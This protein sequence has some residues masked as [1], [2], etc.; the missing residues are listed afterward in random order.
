[1]RQCTSLVLAG[2]VLLSVALFTLAPYA[3]CRYELRAAE[4]ALHRNDLELAR[5][6]LERSLAKGPGNTHALFLA[7]QT[8]WRRRRPGGWMSA[9]RPSAG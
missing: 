8:A 6:H 9:P 3:W 7:A 2:L 4:Q 5:D 1:M